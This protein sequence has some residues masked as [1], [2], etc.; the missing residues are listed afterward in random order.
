MANDRLK[1]QDHPSEEILNAFVD[2]EF[3][4]EDRLSTLQAIASSEQLSREVCDMHQL[5]ELVSMAYEEVQSPQTG[6]RCRLT[7]AR[8]SAWF[9]SVAAGVVA[10]VLG[11]LAGYELTR[12]ASLIAGFGGGNEVVGA[13]A[14]PAPISASDSAPL[15]PGE[16]LAVTDGDQVLLHI[17]DADTRA[18]AELLDDIET[19]YRD[20]RA[21]GRELDVQVVV[22]NKA[23]DLVRADRAPYPERVAALVEHYPGLRFTACTQT[24]ERLAKEE[25]HPIEILPQAERIDSGVAEAARRQAQGWIYIKV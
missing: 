8:R 13:P 14:A 25:G 9:P 7:H 16:L 11:S 10:L 3:S 19:M 5:K 2:G 15:P 18:M 12:D 24:L 1:A 17:N 6:G 23:M 20:A 22:H 21:G 4:P